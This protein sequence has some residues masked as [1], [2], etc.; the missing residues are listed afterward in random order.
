MGCTIFD[1]RLEIPTHAHAQIFEIIAAG[2]FGQKIKVFF[3]CLINRWNAHK[4]GNEKSMGVAALLNKAV[5]AGNADSSLLLFIAGIDLNEELKLPPLL[6]HFC[7]NGPG[8][9]RSV[10]RVDCIK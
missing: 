8:N 6:Y 9:T 2:N 1:C 4:T 5:S 7:S 10:Y 3:R